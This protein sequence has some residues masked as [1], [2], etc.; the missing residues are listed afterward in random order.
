MQL[1]KII[2]PDAYN[3]L[4][5]YERRKISYNE[6]NF[7][8]NTYASAIVS[9]DSG[10]RTPFSISTPNHDYYSGIND[11]TVNLG[12]KPIKDITLRV[13]S[14]AYAYDSIEII[15]IPKTEYKANLNALAEEHLE[16][17]NISVNEISG[18]IKLCFFQFRIMKT[19]RLMQTVKKPRFTKQ[20]RAFAQFRLKPANTKLCLN[21]KTSSLN[22]HRP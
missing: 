15:C 20:T 8:P 11:F 17:L 14:G 4:T 16:D 7:E 18:N 3:K 2:S 5:T 6:K 1:K 12:D 19:G 22:Y 21:T 10:A 9:S 13:G